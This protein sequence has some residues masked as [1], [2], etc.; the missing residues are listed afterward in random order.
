MAEALLPA[1]APALT[2]W[3]IGGSA[4]AVA[5]TTWRGA[6]G[7][8]AGEAE[9]RLLALAGQLLGA[10][11]L[12]EPSGAVQMLPDIPSLAKPPIGEAHRPRV[13][14]LLLALRETGQR[15]ALL[16]LLDRR[17]WTMHP[18]DW[19]PG[20]NEDGLPAVYSPWQDWVAQAGQQATEIEGDISVE[21]W[22]DFGPAAR[23]VAF[24]AL[25]RRDPVQAA[26][27]LAAK[28]ASETP[29]RRLLFL[30]LLAAD[31]A[32]SDQ[33]ALEALA[34]DRA[35][36]VKVRA[37]ALLAR[38]GHGMAVDEDASELAGFFAVKTRG[39]LRKSLAI[40][41]QE[42]KTRTQRNRRAA[43]MDA[44][45]FGAMAQAL[46]LEPEELA[47]AWPWG[48]DAIA[49]QALATMMERSAS[50]AA[51]ALAAKALTAQATVNL[52]SLLPLLPRMSASGRRLV[53][54]Q[55]LAASGGSFVQALAVAGGDGEID[56]AIGTAAG[57]AAL[58]ALAGCG[59]DKPDD[60]A[61]ELIA[62][63]L[64]ASQAAAVQAL[65]KLAEAG[66]IASDPRLE[67]LR[68]NAALEP[69]GT[70]P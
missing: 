58:T 14:R 1:L 9:L 46:E 39:W 17:G 47:A 36:R 22:D 16:G 18:G 35:P 57:Q 6:L 11:T 52:H 25:R 15:H 37:A 60:H 12:A 55:V 42:L 48:G 64:L 29:D 33:A 30:D 45:T 61:A 31:L 24:T 28:I 63:G 50:D 49:D 19:M 68:L 53:T 20:A 69:G 23:R 34:N 70:R 40:V 3:T 41:P 38:L 13:R 4:A 44:L 59:A 65:E 5:P 54:S 7:V 51:V 2:R 21:N 27:A 43:L 66:L 56:N 32:P 67:M 8:D 10:L 62:L 26:A